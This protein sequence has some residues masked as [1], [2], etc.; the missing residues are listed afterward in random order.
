MNLKLREIMLNDLEYYFE[1]NH[2]DKSFHNFN[3]PYFKKQTEA[4]LKKYIEKLKEKLLNWETNVL[5]SKKLI[6]NMDTDELIWEVNWYWKSEE[7]LWMEIW[8]VI[9]NEDYW[10]KWIWFEAMNI[11]INEL[12]KENKNIVRLW[13]STWSW[14]KA[15]MA[16]AMKLGFKKEAVY[17]KARIVNNEYFDSVSYWI[18]REECEK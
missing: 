9:F 8:I 2:P 3:G 16:L 18:L 4:E 10:G 11:W 15:M 7:T 14:N 1:L 12:F 13:L 5:K 17:R 6:V